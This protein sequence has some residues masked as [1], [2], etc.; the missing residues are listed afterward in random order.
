MKMFPI[1][2]KTNTKLVLPFI[3]IF[4]TKLSTRKGKNKKYTWNK[5]ELRCKKEK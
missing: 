5:M 2:K 3:G 4:V 1:K